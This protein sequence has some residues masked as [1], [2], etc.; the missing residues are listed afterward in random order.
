MR[1]GR[2]TNWAGNVRFGAAT[3]HRPTSV[4]ALRKLV[5]GADRLHPLGTGHSFSRVADSD[6]AAGAAGRAGA[7]GAAGAL[8]TVAGLPPEAA[9]DRRRRRVTVSAG[10]RLGELAP[11]LHRA[12]FALPGLPSL[13]H[14]SVAGACA[15]ATHGSGDRIGNLASSVTALELVTAGGKLLRLDREHDGDRFQGVVVGL[16]GLGIV[17]RLTL[18]L[19]PAFEVRQ[20][21][22]EGLPHDTLAQR[23]PEIFAA[24][25]SV[26]VF[27]GWTDARD[28]QVWLKQREDAGRP[29]ADRPR[30]EWLGA[31]LADSARHPIPGMPAANCTEQLGVP[32]PWYARLPHF[33]LEFTPSSGSELQSEYLLPRDRAGAAL[34]AIDQIRDRVAPVLQI[35]EVRTVAADELWLSPS[36]RRD[37]VAIHFTWV[38]DPAAVLP[39]IAA[40]EERLVPLGARPHWGK[41]FGMDPEAVRAQYPRWGDFVTLTRDLDP[42]GTFRNEFLDTYLPSTRE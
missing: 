5:A 23:W 25:Y 17:T 10:M 21:V 24:G 28:A 6:G 42:A 26:S 14:I 38:A 11:R 33:R 7:A 41:L 15:T 13:P 27:T 2:F 16:G 20:H 19:V 37:T 39:A 40:V 35:S 22:Y 34:A 18:D 3:I 9:V 8:V 4:P 31:R 29:P 32:G 30:Q 1:A 12:G 36:Y